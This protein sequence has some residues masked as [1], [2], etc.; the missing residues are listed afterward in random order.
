MP[1]G[2]ARVGAG[3]KPHKRK[4][5]VL[6]MDGARR[7]PPAAADPV[8]PSPAVAALVDVD[9]LA[10][11]PEDLTPAEKA[12]WCSYAPLAIDQQ[13]LTPAT[14]VGFRELCTVAVLTHAIAES[15]ELARTPGKDTEQR[16]AIGD[17][18]KLY[19]KYAQRLDGLLARFKLTAFGKPVDGAGKRQQPAANSWADVA[20]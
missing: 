12:V 20:K 4:G 18:L 15:I 7:E 11:A 13:T 3:R 17:G 2:G 10:I 9:E 5:I 8:E 1:R 6:Q 16:S 19:T 14:A